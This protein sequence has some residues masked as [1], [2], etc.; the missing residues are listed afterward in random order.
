MVP[1]SIKLG[2]QS[3]LARYLDLNYLNITLPLSLLS[4]L[5]EPLLPTFPQLTLSSLT[6][7]ITLSLSQSCYQLTLTFSI[8]LANS[9]TCSQSPFQSRSR[10]HSSSP[11]CFRFPPRFVAHALDL[12]LA[13]HLQFGITRYVSLSLHLQFEH[14]VFVGICGIFCEGFCY[15]GFCFVVCCCGNL[16]LFVSVSILLWVFGFFPTS[17]E[18]HGITNMNCR[19]GN[20]DHLR[21]FVTVESLS[22]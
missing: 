2:Y 4:Q 13:L 16:L 20:I 22:P 21:Y 3:V 5:L 8:L 18:M 14:W 15:K 7:S 9:P 19:V 10:S 17:S 1:E 12:P 11:S 6:F